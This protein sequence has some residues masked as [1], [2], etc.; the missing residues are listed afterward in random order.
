MLKIKN[1][2]AMLALSLVVGSCQANSVDAQTNAE[3]RRVE[4]LVKSTPPLYKVSWKVCGV[5]KIVSMSRNLKNQCLESSQLVWGPA[6]QYEMVRRREFTTGIDL[7]LF[8]KSRGCLIRGEAA[9]EGYYLMKDFHVG[10]ANEEATLPKPTSDIKIQQLTTKEKAVALYKF[11]TSEP[12]PMLMG[13]RSRY[14]CQAKQEWL[15]NP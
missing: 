9:D 6:T 12:D 8:V 14:E 10:P 15:R 4:G 13:I 3:L 5:Q 11:L 2:V 1:A 7:H